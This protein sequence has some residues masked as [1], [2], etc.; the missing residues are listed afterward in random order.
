MHIE[1]IIYFEDLILLHK[2]FRFCIF[3]FL[4][5]F[6]FFMLCIAFIPKIK[7]SM[8]FCR[9]LQRHRFSLTPKTVHMSFSTIPIEKRVWMCSWISLLFSEG[10]Y[11]VSVFPFSWAFIVIYARE[12][13]QYIDSNHRF[14][15]AAVSEYDNGNYYSSLFI[16]FHSYFC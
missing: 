11:F 4:Y 5:L 8:Q 12:M 6:Y 9:L 10:G 2:I 16:S 15:I 1:S 3:H 7:Y 13:Y 14:Y